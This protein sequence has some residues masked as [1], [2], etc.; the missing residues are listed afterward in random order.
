MKQ[1]HPDLF[2][3]AKE[4]EYANRKNGNAFYWNGDEPLEELER[5]ERVAQIIENWETQRAR[6]RKNS[7]TLVS[8]LGGLEED[9]EEREGCLICQI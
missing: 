2:E 9:E 4:Y 1:E 3:K 6:D 8:I 5:P 7:A